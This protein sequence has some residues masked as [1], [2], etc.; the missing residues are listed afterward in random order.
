MLGQRVTTVSITC[1]ISLSVNDVPSVV[2]DN[3]TDQQFLQAV[4]HL[5]EIKPKQQAFVRKTA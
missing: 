4:A 5:Y 2:T 1:L 3:G